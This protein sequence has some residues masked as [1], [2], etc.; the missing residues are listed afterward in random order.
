MNKRIEITESEK[1]R[2]LNMHESFKGSKII[3]EQGEPYQEINRAIQ[4]FLNEKKITDNSGKPLKVDGSIGPNSKS[5]EAIDKYQ[6]KIG[7]PIG[8]WTE[9]T[10]E[11]MPEKDRERLKDLIAEEGG[12]I[13]RFFRWL[14]KKF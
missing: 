9:S 8:E 6:Q 13:S 12:V 1:R 5:Q 2:I 11:K 10:W 3:L 4:R 7:A 14:S